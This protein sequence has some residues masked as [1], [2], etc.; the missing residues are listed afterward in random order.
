MSD[1]TRGIN[2]SFPSVVLRQSRVV[3][4]LH[5]QSVHVEDVTSS[6]IIIITQVILNRQ[7]VTERNPRKPVPFRIRSHNILQ[8]TRIVEK[9]NRL[10]AVQDG[11]RDYK[12]TERPPLVL[13]SLCFLRAARHPPERV[14]V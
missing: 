12:L 1:R 2:F 6:I 10:N 14:N 7:N 3:R 4:I 11:L 5:G 13:S 8:Y 9:N